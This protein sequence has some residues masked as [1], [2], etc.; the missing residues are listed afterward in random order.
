MLRVTESANAEAAKQYF[1]KGM[2]RSDYY[3][4][5]QEIA[6]VWG[7]KAAEQLG[8]S[9]E[10]K[11][12]DYF[13]V[14]DNIHP[15]TGEQLTPRQKDNRRAGYDFTFSAPKTVSVLYEI[16]KD[17]RILE[18]FRES[19]NETMQ[20][21]EREMKTRVRK[22]G[23]DEN[24]LTGNMVWA[25]FVHFTSR[26]VNGV[27]DP[28]LH[29]HNFAANITWD[30]KERRFKAGQFGELKHDAEYFEAAFDAR[31]AKKL[32][33]LGII[34]HKAGYSFEVAGLPTSLIDKFSRRRDYVEAKAAER[35]ITSP[36]GKH[37]IGYYSREQKN[38]G[39]GKTALRK[40]WDSRLSPEERTAIDAAMQGGG[41]DGGSGPI[42]PSQAMDYSVQHSFERASVVSD[43]RLRGEALRYGV[44][45]I[46]PGDVAGISKRDGMIA[47]DHDG[48]LMATTNKVLSDE[49]AMLQFAR[50]GQRK[51]RPLVYSDAM[52][53]GAFKGLS[54][55]QE[56]A[57]RHILTSRDA[58]TGIVGKAGTGKTRMMRT[59]VDV[60]EGE[61]GKKVFTFAPSAQ[62]S[63]KVLASEGFKDATTLETLLKSEKLQK[64]TEG[65][66]IWVDEAGLVS[67]KDMKRLMDVA[68][69][70]GNRVILSGDYTQHSSVEAGDAFRLMEQQGGV[71]LA[72]LTEVRRQTDAGYKKAVEDIA[73]GS[74]KAAQKGFD[75]LDRMDCVIEATGDDR[76]RMLVSDYL[77][78]VDDGKSGL[79]VAP[80][81]AEG[82]RLTDELRSHLKERGVIGAER[83]FKVRKST[84]WTAAQKGDIRNYEPGM[85]IDFSDAIAGTRRSV[86]GV[87]A[88]FGGFKK[89]EAVAVLSKDAEG[90]VVVRKDGR[91]G[92]LALNQADRFEVSRAR[93]LAIGKGDRIR[94]TRNGEARVDGQAKGTRLNNGDIYTVEGF[95]KQGNIRIGDG[96]LLAKDYGH[97]TFGYVDTSYASQGKTVDRVFIATGN[98]S[99][100]AANQQQWYVSVTRGREMAKVYVD[101][102]EDVRNA[103]AKTGQRLSAVELTGAKLT[104]SW[105]KRYQES[106]ERNRVGRFIKT[107]AASL[108][109]A[110]RGRDKGREGM[111]YGR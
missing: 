90:L 92:R 31:F 79:I 106:F 71:R 45:S 16:S 85:V 47:G 49:M 10:V 40:E 97:F 74:G 61:T 96:K 21:I 19:T 66:I 76:H 24:R 89:G 58:V 84:G 28:H 107:Y 18:A 78:A 108:A 68:K 27:P 91:Q 93:E 64:Q 30:E 8:L 52:P 42:T 39:I 14:V 103:I 69:K 102:K 23:K 94:I 88:T 81:H 32:N 34:T 101:S 63:R 44:G 75:A 48:E 25:E 54:P 110:W 50:D 11:Q 51:F 5:G 98:E 86:K 70:G 43:K 4:D 37:A 46:L 2:V 99:L 22:N 72:K 104:D 38:E 33:D 20:E 105:R 35:G 3:I 73:Q 77:K 17:K 12:A 13:A 55:E 62:A 7:G 60:I 26:P 87:R 41:N 65:Q 1:G 59:T 15:V 56:A 36:E 6:G 83:E 57:A 100:R 67:S 53:E 9:G 29:S 109:S 95:D 111:S 82:G 80:T